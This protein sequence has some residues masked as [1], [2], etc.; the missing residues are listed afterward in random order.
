MRTLGSL[1]VR[2]EDYG[3]QSKQAHVLYREHILNGSWS[4]SS[5]YFGLKFVNIEWCKYLS[6]TLVVLYNYTTQRHFL[7]TS[8]V[9]H[10]II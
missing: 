4:F 9:T 5:T 8:C 1:L 7:G 3:V 6:F 10:L 2:I